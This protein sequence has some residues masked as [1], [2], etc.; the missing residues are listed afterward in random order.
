MASRPAC[1]GAPDALVA[2]AMMPPLTAPQPTV[3]PYSRSPLPARFGV[4][5]HAVALQ[6][7]PVTQVVSSVQL[8]RHA[9]GGPAEHRKP[10]QLCAV[11]A[12]QAPAPLQ[13]FC[14]MIDELVPSH[15]GVALQTVLA[16][17][18][19]QAPAPLQSP[20]KPQVDGKSIVHSL[21]V[22]IPSG[23]GRQRPLLARSQR[24]QSPVHCEAQQ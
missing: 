22:S 5:T 13:T 7:P 20:V 21:S 11:L 15:A 12:T 4:A 16:P 3:V 19:R 9:T 14:G 10:L 6:K 2:R 18:F 23:T 24:M 8:V 1:G 17:Y